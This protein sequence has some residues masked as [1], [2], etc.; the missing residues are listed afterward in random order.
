MIKLRLKDGFGPITN[1][2]FSIVPGQ[3]IKVEE[4]TPFDPDVIEQ[5][6]IEES[7]GFQIYD[8]TNEEST[9]MTIVADGDFNEIEEDEDDE[10]ETLEESKSEEIQ[11][12]KLTITKLAAIKG[13]G[14]KTAKKILKLVKTDIE[15]FEKEQLLRDELND[16]YVDVLIKNLKG[17]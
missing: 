14:Y 4:G 7:T 9:E 12:T 8:G 3:V 17:E 16:N 15:V 5:V 11:A 10:D 2:K 6:E 13:I 1:S